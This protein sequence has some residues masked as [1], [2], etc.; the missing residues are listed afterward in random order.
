[1]NRLS[2]SSSTTFQHM[3]LIIPSRYGT[4]LPPHFISQI[5]RFLMRHSTSLVTAAAILTLAASSASAAVTFIGE[6]V[7]P[8]NGTDLSGLPS[9][10]LEDGHSPQNA[11]NGFGSGIAYAGGN[12][13]ELLA[14]RGPNKIAYTG[15]AAVD[16]TTSFDNR[17]QTF[18]LSFTPNG[19]LTNGVYTSYTV[20]ATNT[21]TTL[22]SNSQGV[23]YQGL[24]TSFSTNPL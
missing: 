9:S 19:P 14:D 22:L 13:F 17:Y 21:A 18:S 7:I 20:N 2:P 15:G 6:A 23:Q 16:N 10:L 3:L 24:S 4:T 5:R 12:T 8:G 1:M 11:L